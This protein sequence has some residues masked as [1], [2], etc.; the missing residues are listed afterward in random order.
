MSAPIAAIFCMPERGHLQRLLPLVAEFARRGVDTRVYTNAAYREP[1]ERA[2]GRLVDLFQRYPLDDADATSRPIPSRYVTFAAHYAAPLL[3][4]V[5]R[6]AP[7]VIVYDTFAVIGYLLGRRLGIPYVNVCVG[8]A[9]TPGRAVAALERDPRVA[10]SDACRRA[11]DM[12]RDRWGIADATPFAYYTGL[13]P[14]LNVYCEPSEFLPAEDRAAFEP[15][16]FLGSLPS[17]EV[18]GSDP[19][20]GESPFDG[21]GAGAFRVYVSFGTVVWRYY[22]AVALEA[23]G[24][25]SAAL[26]GLGH[27][28]T[29]ISLGGHLLRAEQRTPLER[30]NVRVADYVDQRRVLLNAS[31]FVT[32]HGLNSTHEA[33]YHRVPMLSYPF[34]VSQLRLA[35]RCQELGLALP[36]ADAPRAAISEGAVRATLTRLEERAAHMAARLAQARA[37]EIAVMGER[38]TVVQ[39]I[40]DL[41]VKPPR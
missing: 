2:G 30:R 16:A 25:L 23:L 13:S 24:A 12:L 14:F 33:V 11:V 41:G 28:R 34:S 39:R 20:P 37:W 27:A 38:D 21:D 35:A 10:T 32:H 15:I 22:E 29:L 31:L 36:L 7:T 19:G 8:H 26:S 18:G 4:E 5:A 6:L 9:M 40:L 1:V 3:D 17:P